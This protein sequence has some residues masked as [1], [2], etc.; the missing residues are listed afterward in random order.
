MPG[1]DERFSSKARSFP[2]YGYSGISR[3]LANRQ[4]QPVLCHLDRKSV[5]AVER[6]DFCIK[7]N[8]ACRNDFSAAV[9][10]KCPWHAGP[11]APTKLLINGAVP[12]QTISSTTHQRPGNRGTIADIC[13]DAFEGR[14]AIVNVNS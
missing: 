13:G 1:I 4:L 5:F 14:L 6:G 9:G 2:R 8:L 3:T 12:K 10:D 11:F 7:L